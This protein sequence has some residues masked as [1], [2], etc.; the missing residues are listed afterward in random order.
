MIFETYP[1]QLVLVRHG[2]S[3]L[4]VAHAQSPIFFNSHEDRLPFLEM[5]DHRVG[6]SEKGKEE[7]R[8]TGTGLKQ[9]GFV[10]DVCYDSGYKRTVETLD[11]VLEN[12]EQRSI[13]IKRTYSILLRER[14]SGYAYCMTKAEVETAFPWLQEYWRTLGPIFARPIGGESV[15]DVIARVQ[16]FLGYLFREEQ[17]KRVLLVLHGRIVATIRFLLENWTY[18]ELEHFL[19]HGSPKN[20]GVTTYDRKGDSVTLELQTYNKLYCGGV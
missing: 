12:L 14:E 18:D 20:C 1:Q 17:G 8:M 2:E 7:A 11:L 5:P 6:L 3:L 13:N 4:N 15:A 9:D 19:T 10:F 16:T